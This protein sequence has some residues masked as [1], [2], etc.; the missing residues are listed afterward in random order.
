MSDE[1]K[2]FLLKNKLSGVVDLHY[3]ENS[4]KLSLLSGDVKRFKVP[5]FV[6][7][8][9]KVY[10]GFKCEELILGSDCEVI[11]DYCFGVYSN[12]QYLV[13]LSDN[14]M[15]CKY[16]FLGS[17]NL[18]SVKLKGTVGISCN[19]FMHCSGLE[20]LNISDVTSIIIGNEA[21][22]NC[23]S[24]SSITGLESVG[25]ISLGEKC[26]SDCNSL[27][28]VEFSGLVKLSSNCF[29]CC[30]NLKE[31]TFTEVDFSDALS[32]FDGCSSDLII[33]LPKKYNDIDFLYKFGVSSDNKPFENINF[34]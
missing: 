27:E 20:T 13:S 26:F 4:H 19:C 5:D 6:K 10:N 29:C 23:R 9:H 2:L 24:L 25:Y 18:K 33:N 7:S 22:K 31:V 21:F 8:L 17:S 28:N 30:N 15:F 34:Y 12:I 16:S 1:V 3:Y 11:E 32:I 14:L